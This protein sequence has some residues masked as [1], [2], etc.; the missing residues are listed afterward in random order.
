[1]ALWL[2]PFVSSVKKHS[3]DMDPEILEI[4]NGFWAASNISVVKK[5]QLDQ[6]LCIDD[7]WQLLS[8]AARV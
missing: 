6:T 7:I 2:V 8:W 5:Q 1:M 4:V 3:G